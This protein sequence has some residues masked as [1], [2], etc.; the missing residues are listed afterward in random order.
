MKRLDVRLLI[1]LAA[2]LLLGMTSS[3]AYNEVVQAQGSPQAIRIF[4]TRDWYAQ[5]NVLLPAAGNLIYHS[6]PVMHTLQAFAI[7]W[8]PAGHSMD[9]GYQNLLSRYFSDVGGSGFN[10]IL[11][12]YSDNPGTVHI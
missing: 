11:T 9:S 3:L 2:L 4:H 7:F 5:H 6:G 1:A 12:Q 10:N 8:V